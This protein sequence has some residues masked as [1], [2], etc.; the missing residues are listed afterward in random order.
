MDLGRI[1]REFGGLL[2]GIGTG[3]GVDGAVDFDFCLRRTIDVLQT[4]QNERAGSFP[5]EVVLA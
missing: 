5:R 1:E 3:D 4:L 2:D